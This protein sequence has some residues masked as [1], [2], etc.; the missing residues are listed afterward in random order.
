MNTDDIKRL[1]E[2][3]YNGE[4]N[5]EEEQILRNYFNN[6]QIA[7]ELADEKEIFAQ[8]HEAENIDIPPMLESNLES[9]IDGLARQEEEKRVI[10]K[11]QQK[12]R[13]IMRWIG[14][15]AAGIAILISVGIYFNSNRN[16][17]TPL[18][19]QTELKDTYS[20]PEEA[21]REA[22]KALALVSSNFNKGV[23]Q[24]AVVSE[25]IDKANEILNRTLNRKNNKES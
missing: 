1:I 4:T 7:E 14:S 2:A 9:L 5:H 18:T 12:K 23:S 10:L 15:A 22:Q 24:V 20:D 11:P 21:Y 8:L 13:H 6:D 19:G 16:I 3:F 17:D 25:N